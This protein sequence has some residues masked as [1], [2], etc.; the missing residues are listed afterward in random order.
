V[1]TLVNQIEAHLEALEQLDGAIAA[2]KSK[3]SIDSAVTEILAWL[4]LLAGRQNLKAILPRLHFE[5]E[6]MRHV[7]L[8]FAEWISISEDYGSFATKISRPAD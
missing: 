8:Q 5:S 7:S 3:Q 6:V 1:Q 4:S 2:G